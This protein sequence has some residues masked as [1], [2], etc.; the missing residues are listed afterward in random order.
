MPYGLHLFSLEIKSAVNFCCK[1]CPEVEIARWLELKDRVYDHP[2]V[3]SI[4]FDN[5]TPGLINGLEIPSLG[6]VDTWGQGQVFKKLER[7]GN[8]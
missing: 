3:C 6:I 1:G 2:A 7:G 5:R 4:R 8:G